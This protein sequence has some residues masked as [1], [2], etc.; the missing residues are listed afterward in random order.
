MLKNFLFLLTLFAVN[1]FDIPYKNIFASSLLVSSLYTNPKI[2]NLKNI[3]STNNGIPFIHHIK[4]NDNGFVTTKISSERNNIYLYG[5]ITP[6][7]C[8]ELKNRLNEMEF[9]SRLYKVSYNSD[10]P[11]IQLHI[12]STG[13]SLMNA[14]YIV[15]LIENIETPVYTYVD[16][17]SASAA[18]L[19][20]VV[21]KK[22]FM[23]KNSL[24]MIHQLYSNNEGK[25]NELDDEMTNL[26]N[27]MDKIKNIYTKHTNIPLQNLDEM[28][29][30]DLWF[31]SDLSKH[32]GLI[33]EIL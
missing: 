29:K 22:R 4:N 31:D 17:Y 19:I 16:G 21:G 23:T 14:L 11:P 13:G 3:V 32:F 24:I 26:N 5:Q 10:P 7:S 33:D 18:S 1:S 27:M 20:N 12:Q 28:L 15:D 25:Y 30:H 2:D 8:E 6:E 9:N